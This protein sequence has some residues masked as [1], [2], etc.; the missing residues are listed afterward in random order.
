MS[1]QDYQNVSCVGDG[2]EE[3][4]PAGEMTGLMQTCDTAPLAFARRHHPP[5]LGIM[6]IH[7]SISL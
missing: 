1:A 2:R 6:A 5:D 4:L 7:M 3:M